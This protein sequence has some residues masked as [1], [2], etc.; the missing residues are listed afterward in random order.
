M[1][2]K[3]LIFIVS[4]NAE[5]TI[6]SVLSRIPKELTET[7]ILIIDDASQDKTLE[8]SQELLSE[9]N[10]RIFKNPKNLGYGGNQKLGY[11]YAIENDFDIVALIHG[12]GQYAPE[13]LPSLLKPLIEES[14][15]AVFGSR[16][17]KKR[18]AL[19][20]GMP[21]YKYY[22]NKILSLSLIHI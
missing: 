17:L 22:G 8:R 11:K 13:E 14:A 10:L 16:M 12:D 19:K 9:L 2:K 18:A 15:D 1:K 3:I 21:T 7:E 6:G 20:G 5:R 4:Y